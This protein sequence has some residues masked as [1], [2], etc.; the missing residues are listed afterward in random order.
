M[1]KQNWKAK[2]GS[3]EYQEAKDK[4]VR[5]AI[6][7]IGEKG[8]AKFRFDELAKR[9]G[10]VRTT[11]YRYFDS[12]DELLTEVITALMYQMTIDII[13]YT[14]TKKMLSKS[15]F[16][17]GVYQAIRQLQT[18]KHY[19]VV[20]DADNIMLFSRLAREK[21]P[22]RMVPI[23]TNYLSEDDRKKM[24]SKGL[25]IEESCAWLTTQIIAYAQF[26]LPGD[27]EKAQ[28]NYVKKMIVSILI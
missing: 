18:A 21:V 26:G 9:V 3:P 22:E 16:A 12:K 20:M 24:V 28:K 10:C 15:S 7:I 6:T 2:A 25:T 13:R 19:K 4:I 8:F 17:E 14:A 11:L 23:L 5:E 1:D 27:N